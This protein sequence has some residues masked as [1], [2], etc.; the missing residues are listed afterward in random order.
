M[1]EIFEWESDYSGRI[2]V[3]GMALDGRQESLDEFQRKYYPGAV[4]LACVGECDCILKP[5]P[6]E[7]IEI[8]KGIPTPTTPT[9][10]G[11]A[12]ILLFLDGVVKAP[13][14]QEPKARAPSGNKNPD[15]TTTNYERNLRGGAVLVENTIRPVRTIR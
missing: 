9:P 7:E 12:G 10:T 6:V 15:G 2:C 14:N 8:L 13:D 11:S 5:V 3:D 1:T 4:F